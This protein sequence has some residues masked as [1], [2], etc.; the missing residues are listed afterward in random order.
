MANHFVICLT[1]PKLTERKRLMPSELWLVI[2]VGKFASHGASIE[3]L[4]AVAGLA[5]TTSVAILA[6]AR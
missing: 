6:R 3:K 5:A 4:P 2:W 1:Q